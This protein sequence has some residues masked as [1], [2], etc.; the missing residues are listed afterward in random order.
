[1][2]ILP[3]AGNRG[4]G[5]MKPRIS[6]GMLAGVL[7]LSGSSPALAETTIFEEIICRV[8]ND[9]ITKSE[10]EEAAHLLKLR[11]QG[12]KKLSGEQLAQAV[13]EG[14]KDLLKTM[15]EERLLV[16][17]AVEL[18]MTADTDVIKYL[19]RLR[20]ENNLP[21]IEALEQTMR[22]QGI[23][24]VEFRKR[25]KEQSLKEQVLGREVY[26]RIQVSTAEI[27]TFYEANRDK[28]DRPEQVR[29]QEILIASNG[30]GPS[31]A[32]G[33]RK[34]AEEVLEKARGGEVFGDL[35]AQYSEGP[36]AKQGGD[37]GFFQRGM[38]LKEVEE[39]VF[40]LRRGQITD[41]LEGQGGFRIFKV[42]EK[43][44]AGIQPLD[45]VKDQIRNKLV[46]DKAVPAV[47]KYMETLRRQSYIRLKDGYVDSGAEV[48]TASAEGDQ[49]AGDELPPAAFEGKQKK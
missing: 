1:M 13:S 14:E 6:H 10:Y 22:Q 5:T 19:D 35:V 12:Q 28:F 36:T 20:S 47:R 31:G 15:I 4:G 48:E 37:L 16:Q 3:G 49:P 11:V 29:L 45:S 21:S 24:P 33:L 9:I 2:R 7:L 44:T 42:I 38:L 32:G 41:I 40:S 34:R 46:E 27:K 39:I 18:G 43:N 8:N 17:K 26:Y 25:I 23:N 30:K